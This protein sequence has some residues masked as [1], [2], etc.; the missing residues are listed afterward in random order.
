MREG[1]RHM[2]TDKTNTLEINILEDGFEMCRHYVDELLK[3]EKVSETIY[4]ETMFVFEAIYNSILEQNEGT[5]IVLTLQTERKWGYTS[6]RFGFEGNMYRDKEYQ[7]GRLT[8]EEKIVKAYS[9]RIDHSYLAGYNVIRLAIKHS[10]ATA[11]FPCVVAF[12]AATIVYTVLCFFLNKEERYFAMTEVV[13]PIEQWCANL[14]LMVGAP[15]TFVSFVKNLT[16]SFII[17]DRQSDVKKIRAAII[18]SSV[19]S[20][21]LAVSTLE[22]LMQIVRTPNIDYNSPMSVEGSLPD[23]LAN[24]FPADIF[25]PFMIYSPFPLL[26]LAVIVTVALCSVGKYFDRLKQIIDIG[27]VLFSKML[28]IIMC[29]LP[30]FLFLAIMDI[31][32][33]EGFSVFLPYLVIIPTVLLSF[34]VLG[35]FY[36]IRLA[37][38]RIPVRD[39]VRKLGPLLKEN[40]K[41]G[42]TIDAAPFNIRYCAKAW[43]LDRKKLEINV[44][45]LAETNLD[46]NCFFMTLI[47]LVL[48]FE[49]NAEITFVNM[50]MVGI[51][52]FFLSLGAPNQP[53]SVLIGMLII[54]NFMMAGDLVS[55]AFIAEVLFGGLLN[56]V[57]VLGD[58]VTV[59][60]LDKEG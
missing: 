13:F 23:I 10:R 31:L 56:I 17:L 21:V 30:L 37:A 58:I 8:P 34:L 39:F 7:Y 19:L 25:T 1:T 45:V 55:N 44:P 3:K 12:V 41:I 54:L 52:A 26:I 53:G 29:N 14:V 35:V 4:T 15:V 2:R 42:S 28:N 6:L 59:Y 57:N 60:E 27:Y 48:V 18:R 16:D 32:L 51:L 20:V 36:W 43:S 46:G 38:R 47:P 9:D 50:I 5:G 11:V 40:Y 49:S 24:L 22:I 33:D